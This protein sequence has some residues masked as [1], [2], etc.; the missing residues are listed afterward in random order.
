MSTIDAPEKP[1]PPP[2]ADDH[3][4][5]WALSRYID[6][7]KRALGDRQITGQSLVDAIRDLI[8]EANESQAN[9]YRV[10][11]LEAE[12]A[13]MQRSRDTWVRECEAE[14]AVSTEWERR[15]EM[16]AE[17]YRRRNREAQERERELAELRA[18]CGL[19]R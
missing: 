9:G 10:R 7:A 12:L 2:S 18:R 14:R 4:F 15:A 1:L 17:N 13:D 6:E 8:R 5:R 19:R 11:E 3:A 16:A